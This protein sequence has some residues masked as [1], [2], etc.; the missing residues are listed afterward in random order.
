[1]TAEE[2]PTSIVAMSQ[3]EWSEAVAAAMGLED[4]KD[5]ERVATVLLENG[6]RPGRPRSRHRLKVSAV[7][8]AGLKYVPVTPDD[9]RSVDSGTQTEVVPFAFAHEF[10]DGFTAFATDRVNDAG[11]S[12]ILGVVLWALHGA[13]PVPTLQAD[14]RS[15]WLREAALL[16]DIDGVVHLTCWR[17]DGG[18][19]RGSIYTL[20]SNDDVDLAQLRTVGHAAATRERDA[21]VAGNETR[22]GAADLDVDVESEVAETDTVDFAW[23]ATELASSLVARDRATRIVVFENESEFEAAVGNVMM[24]RLDLEPV[25]VY[26]KKPGALDASDGS[27]VQHGWSALSQALS[28]IDPTAATVLGEQPMLTQHLMGVFLGSRWS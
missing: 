2:Q 25:L 7:Y 4:A 16:F 5:I 17:V 19:P 1:M 18:V 27:V 21:V 10:S 22:A 24:A 12:T 15:R 23:P 20:A 26:A 11:K 28:I 9:R 8:F 3:T 13:A 14:V 6:I